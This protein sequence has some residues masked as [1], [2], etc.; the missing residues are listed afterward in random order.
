MG[1]M[2]IVIRNTHFAVTIDPSV[3]QHRLITKFNANLITYQMVYDYR[4]KTM[5]RLE[6]R[7]FFYKVGKRT[8]YYSIHLLNTFV[9]RVL[10]IGIR[11]EDIGVT[12][13]QE[14]KS[15]TSNISIRD[16]L[17]DRDHQ[18]LYIEKTLNTNPIT[19]IDLPTGKGKTY[20]SMRVITELKYTTGIV[21]LSR[22]IEKWISDVQTL[23][24]VA[25]DEIYVVK[26]KA[27]LIKLLESD[28]K[29][30]FVI[31]SLST[32]RNYIRDYD[33]GTSVCSVPPEGLYKELGLGVML[34]DEVHQSFHA[35]YMATTRLN[36]L[37]VISLSATLDSLDSNIRFMYG[38]LYPENARC[39]SLVKFA[40]YAVVVA[41]N[42]FID[43]PNRVRCEGPKGYSHVMF[44]QSIMRNSILRNQYLVMLEY[45]VNKIYITRRRVGDKLLVLVGTKAMATLVTNYLKRRYMKLSINRYVEED[46]YESVMTSDIS[47]STNTSAGVALDI[48]NL[49]STLQTVSIGS[50]QF[51]VQALGRLREIKDLDVLY[52]YLYSSSIPKQYR[53]HETRRSVISHLAKEYRYEEYGKRLG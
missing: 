3:D 33:N 49:I 11:K 26:G 16:H 21:V 13:D 35:G 38:T 39:G 27:S 50:L 36:P 41:T 34:I 8:F 6:D 18:P 28:I 1:K 24:N 2:S 52:Y 25:E 9:K 17:E 45:Y 5:R 51:N 12:Y 29:Y 40:P 44:E 37:K 19:L 14:Y 20:V 43:N 10:N 48:P 4:T 46:S 47:V 7:R 42:Y 23:T 15:K 31:F 22:Y 32:L 53:L 30:E